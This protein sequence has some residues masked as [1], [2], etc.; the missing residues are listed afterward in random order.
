M[1]FFFINPHHNYCIDMASLW[2]ESLDF[3]KVNTYG[4]NLIT[5]SALL[6]HMSIVFPQMYFKRNIA[7][8]TTVKWFVPSVNLQMFQKITLH[9]LSNT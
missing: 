1:I 4:E 8:F 2:F 9:Y 6:K 5:L 7:L 3:F